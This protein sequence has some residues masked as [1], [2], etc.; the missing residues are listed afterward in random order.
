MK[1]SFSDTIPV[2]NIFFTATGTHTPGFGVSVTWLHKT[3]VSCHT[4]LG[5]TNY[6][7]FYL[8]VSDTL[9]VGKSIWYE[10]TVTNFTKMNMRAPMSSLETGVAMLIIAVLTGIT[11]PTDIVPDTFDLGNAF[12]IADALTTAD[13]KYKRLERELDDMR[14]ELYALRNKK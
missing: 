4:S 11:K 6:F 3:L 1:R 12:A 13:E 2:R 8:D 5:Q 9:N 7:N 10:T 14:K